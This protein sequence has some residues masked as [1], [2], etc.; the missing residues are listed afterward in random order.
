MSIHKKS[1]FCRAKNRDKLKSKKIYLVRHGQTDYNLKGIVQGSGV[2]ASLNDTGR[3]QAMLFFDRYR[4]TAF[5]KVYTSTL[6]RSIESV[7]HFLD[8][9][10]PH[11]KLSGLN[12]INWGYREGIEITPEED[13]YYHGV[14]KSWR[15]GNVTLPIEGG[16]SPQDVYDRQKEAMK[17]ILRHEEEETILVCMHGR[18]MRI[19]LCQLLNYPL[20]CMDIFEHTNL[21]LYLL[22]YTGSMFVVDK[23][24]DVTHLEETSV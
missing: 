22:T 4:E 18:A 20:K 6:K 17:H 10:L 13:A 7:Q 24:N 1:Y 16:E 11:E 19:L 15:D 8:L 14:I 5:D 3:R 23:F 21:G 2:D 12:E 9:G